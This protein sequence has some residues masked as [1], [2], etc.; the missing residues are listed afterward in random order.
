VAPTIGGTV[1]QALWAFT[2][3]ADWSYPALVLGLVT[4]ALTIGARRVHALFPGVLVAVVGGIL[5]TEFGAYAGATVGPVPA[6]WPPIGVDF[7]WAD[8]RHLVLPGLVIAFVGFAEPA[9]IARALSTHERL[10]WNA[11][12]ELVGQGAANVAAALCGAFPVGGSFSRTALAHAAGARTRA[13]GAIAGMVVLA[14]LPWADSL[15]G[16]P[17]AVLAGII[18]AAVAKLVRVHELVEMMAISRAQALVGISALVLTLAFAPRVDLA[19]L[20]AIGLGIAVH[21]WRETRIVVVA[22]HDGDS[23][24]LT[25]EPI[26]VLYFGSA[27]TLYDALIAELAHDR[28]VAR[29]IIDLRRVGRVDY[30]GAVTLHRVATD[31]SGAGLTVSIVPGRRPQGERILQRVFGPG[32]PWIAP[33]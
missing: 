23:R 22:R 28:D 9:A 30:T 31:A 21:L 20:I 10:P 3:P 33:E 32:S 8:L 25:L 6:G 19:L 24:T 7:A 4:I 29:I 17:Q 1:E 2:H 14:F 27:Q 26:G 12:R 18:I 15:A 13:S 5:L 16:L 11:E